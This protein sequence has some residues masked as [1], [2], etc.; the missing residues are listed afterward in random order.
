M[1][2]D[3]SNYIVHLMDP[4]ERADRD[5]SE[6]SASAGTIVASRIPKEVDLVG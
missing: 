6:S 2:V 5:P 4:G 3:C 1:I